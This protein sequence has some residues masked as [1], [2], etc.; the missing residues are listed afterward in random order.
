MYEMRS[1]QRPHYVIARPRPHTPRLMLLLKRMNNAIELD[2]LYILNIYVY[3][4]RIW[5][6]MCES[7]KNWQLFA[8]FG[9]M[10][11]EN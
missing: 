3:V 9:D 1:H 7:R 8:L 2:Q 5:Q 4:D 6:W 11:I 10:P